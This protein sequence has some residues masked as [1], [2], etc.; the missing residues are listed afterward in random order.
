MLKLCSPDSQ[1]KEALL[2]LSSSQFIIK[3]LYRELNE[4]QRILG[5]SVTVVN[6]VCDEPV[7]STG[8]TEVSFKQVGGKSE[9]AN[10]KP[11]QSRDLV[12]VSNRY[13]V[14]SYL[15]E[16]AIEE[17][18]TIPTKSEVR[19]LLLH[20]KPW[21]PASNIHISGSEQGS[22]CKIYP[23]LKR[24]PILMNGHVRSNKK[25]DFRQC[26]NDKLSYIQDI[27]WESSR[28]LRVNKEEF[29]NDVRKHKVLLV[30]DSHVHG[31]AAYMKVFLNNQFEV[32]GYV[33]PGALSKMVMESAKSDIK[34]SQGT[35]F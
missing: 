27:L 29:T 30:G 9:A 7:S 1:Q 22:D 19:R 4:A 15:S 3:L 24:M 35:I 14:L 2:E 6:G 10:F 5:S 31:C 33:K 18:E 25:K 32:C 34:N 26:E 11:L 13:S 21:L 23:L 28:K 8:W 20:P 17:E 16:S 12:P